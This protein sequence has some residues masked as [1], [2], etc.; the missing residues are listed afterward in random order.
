MGRASRLNYRFL[1]RSICTD[2]E[3]AAVGMTEQQAKDAGRVVRCGTVNYMTNARAIIMGQREG[4]VK[5]VSDATTGQILGVHVLGTGAG[6]L[7]G[8]AVLA[9]RLE[10]TVDDLAAV[11]HWHPTL[12]ESLTDAARRALT[13]A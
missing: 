13:P 7:I 4:I 3:Y 11:T 6:E 2:P 8:Q 10:A 12:A 1:P 5:L 9:M